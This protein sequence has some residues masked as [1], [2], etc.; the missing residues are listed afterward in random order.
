MYWADN[1]AGPKWSKDNY[2]RGGRTIDHLTWDM[3]AVESQDGQDLMVYIFARAEMAC[4][5]NRPACENMPFTP[6]SI[7]RREFIAPICPLPEPKFKG[8]ECKQHVCDNCVDQILTFEGD[9]FNG[10]DD[11][12]LVIDYHYDGEGWDSSLHNTVFIDAHEFENTTITVPCMIPNRHFYWRAQYVT[13]QGTTMKSEYA[14][15]DN[16]TCFVPPAWMEVPPL[17]VQECTTLYQA[18]PIPEFDH[19][20]NYWGDEL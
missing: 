7:P 15:G 11:V 16:M 19:L 4:V 2:Q 17:S 18:R 5:W 1:Q 10:T 9:D 13:G 8:M 3:G 14:Y 12:R 6:S 20:T